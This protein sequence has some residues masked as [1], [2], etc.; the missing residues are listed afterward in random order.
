M[1]RRGPPDV[2][3]VP[4]LV[5]VALLISGDRVLVVRRPPDRPF[6]HQWE[7]PGGKVEFGEHPWDAL[8]R[9]LREELN[10]RVTRGRFF[11]IYSHVYDLGGQRVHYVLVAYRCRVARSNVR[12][13]E[14]RRWVTPAQLRRWPVVPG[15]RPIVADLARRREIT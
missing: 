13:R 4:R 1:A 10:L 5:A 3:D 12:E 6:P 15:S 9:E 7:F 2:V 11:G 8:R 14:T